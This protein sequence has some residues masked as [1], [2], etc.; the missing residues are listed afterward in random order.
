MIFIDA[1]VPMYLVGAPHPH[2]YDA[3]LRLRAA[4]SA[5]RRLVTDAGVFQEILRRYSAIRRR[6]A[7]EPAFE[8][9][10]GMVDEVFE[11]A[12]EDVMDARMLLL[13]GSEVPARDAIHA[14]EMR[15]RGVREI[16][17]FDRG[18]EQVPGLTL[19]RG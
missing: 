11:V 14:A 10:R 16:L 19:F 7:I 17:T 6:D 12:P 15:R 9:L 8:A 5:G 1:N 3:S 4:M 13:P 2:T 18:F